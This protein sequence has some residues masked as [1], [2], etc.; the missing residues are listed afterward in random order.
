MLKKFTQTDRHGNMMSKEM[1]GNFLKKK[2]MKDRHGN[3]MAYE[4]DIPES[5]VPPV[6]QVPQYS[7]TPPVVTAAEGGDIDNHPGGPK[8]SDTVPAWL[9]PG[10][11]VVNKEATDLFGDTIKQMNEIGRQIQDQK[12]AEPDGLMQVPNHV[13]ANK[14]QVIKELEANSDWSKQLNRML[15]KYKG[16]YFNKERLYS[17]MAGESS[18]TDTGEK[19]PTSSAAG[20]FQFT[21]TPLKDMR[22]K[23]LVPKDF[24]TENIRN[25]DPHEQL[26]LYEKYLDMW[27]YQG[28]VHLGIMQAAPGAYHNAKDD[29]GWV[30]INKLAYEKD[31][32]G[33]NDNAPWRGK[34]GDITFKSISDYYDK[35]GNSQDLKNVFAE[36]KGQGLSIPYGVSPSNQSQITPAGL[37]VS[38]EKDSTEA[39]LSNVSND[40]ALNVNPVPTY[41]FSANIPNYPSV[42]PSTNRM[43][44]VNKPIPMASSGNISNFMGGI[45]A[46]TVDMTPVPTDNSNVVMD[47]NKINQARN[48]DLAESMGGAIDNFS[49]DIDPYISRKGSD[50]AK[51]SKMPALQNQLNFVSRNMPPQSLPVP[52]YKPEEGIANFSGEIAQTA[53]PKPGVPWNW[54]VRSKAKDELKKRE[55]WNNQYGPYFN[56]DGSPKPESILDYNPEEYVPPVFSPKASDMYHA[57]NNFSGDTQFSPLPVP[58]FNIPTQTDIDNFSG[59]IDPYTPTAQGD[60]ASD[61]AI[62]NFSGDIDQ[63]TPEAFEEITAITGFP[64]IKNGDGTYTHNGVI[65]E[66]VGDGRLQMQNNKGMYGENNYQFNQPAG[67]DLNLQFRE[68]KTAIGDWVKYGEKSQNR[69]IKN[70]LSKWKTHL[71]K[72]INIGK[73][74]IEKLPDVK[75]QEKELNLKMDINQD[76]GKGT[77]SDWKE[78]EAG[79]LEST[80]TTDGPDILQQ[81]VD[82]HKEDPAPS[83]LDAGAETEAKKNKKELGKVEGF[84]KGLLGSLFDKDEL[85]RM[86]VMYAGSRLM[87]YGHGGSLSFAVKNYIGRTDAKDT[88]NQNFALSSKAQETYTAGS[89]QTFRETGDM[90]DLIEKGKPLATDGTVRKF[91]RRVGTG[92]RQYVEAQKYWTGSG[93]DKRVKWI[94]KD[95]RPID[96]LN[97]T[98]NKHEIE[99]TDEYNNAILKFGKE[100]AGMVSSYRNK[101]M[102]VKNA[103]GDKDAV[104]RDGVDP[105]IMGPRLIK[106][107]L[108]NGVALADMPDLIELGYG[109]AKADVS[110]RE[111]QI[112]DLIPYLNGLKIRETTENLHLFKQVSQ[113]K[114]EKRLGPY[115]G[116]PVDAKRFEKARRRIEAIMNR[117]PSFRDWSDFQKQN[118]MLRIMEERWDNLGKVR[119]KETGQWE[120]QPG[121]KETKELQD[122]WWRKAGKLKSS[123]FLEFLND[124]LNK[125]SEELL[126]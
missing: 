123:G 59:D 13:Y 27:G 95:G 26:E 20:L 108:E 122:I 36:L 121:A 15:E 107:A 10:E 6:N 92:R 31:S 104:Y 98:L 2:V 53:P 51:Q 7:A 60:M 1:V 77:H 87:G 58:D 94:T 72:E 67:E 32:D 63:Y 119:N 18:M 71:N 37:P 16:P 39:T 50:V 117:E 85:K 29:S 118:A 96:P 124:E 101:N 79:E 114:G 47:L 91:G 3:Q 57:I 34:D 74:E 113:T 102:K 22:K 66:H 38:G 42:N 93:E 115:N 106:W 125:E 45:P 8:G 33:W 19:N 17:M 83:T 14:G 116:P 97:W 78:F 75:Q 24:T 64:I 120:K 126:K 112:T 56:E 88:A 68:W 46:P 111:D 54:S 44:E 11:F 5:N 65:Y 100:Y 52:T 70:D 86:A 49:G 62:A 69:D 30:D 28:N 25:M 109:A 84:L 90:D 103:S 43:L 48:A 61:M 89:L 4:F 82:K 41:N 55:E 99:D 9:T 23:G 40:T 35:Q 21:D 76:D 73:K 105:A 81:L 12:G 110:N 80:E